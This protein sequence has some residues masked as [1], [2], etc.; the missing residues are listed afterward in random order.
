MTEASDQPRERYLLHRDGLVILLSN[1]Q[2]SVNQKD[3]DWKSL[4]DN[5]DLDRRESVIIRLERI[6]DMLGTLLTL[7]PTYQNLIT[8][9]LNIL[10]ILLTEVK[11]TENKNLTVN[12][13]SKQHFGNKGAPQFDITEQMLEFY[14]ENGFT[15][16]EISQML[17]VSES[18]IKRR[19]SKY[20]MYIRDTYSDL[21]DSQLDK[22]IEDILKEFPN[23]GYKCMRGFLLHRSIKIQENRVRLSMRRVDP[24]G[25]ML[26]TMQSRPIF[27]RKYSVAGPLSL[28]HMD[29]NHKLI[30]YKMVIHGCVDGFTR[31]IIYLSCLNNNRSSNVLKLFT[32]GI[33]TNGLPSRVRGD[34]GGENIGV[35]RFMLSHPLR[36]TKRG[37]FIASKSVHNTRIEKLWGN[38]T[39]SVTQI[40]QNLFM[41]LE[42]SGDLV[43]DKEEDLFCLQFVFLPRINDHLTRYSR[44]WNYHGLS[45]EKYR[46]PNQLWIK[47][48][49]KVFGTNSRIDK[50][51]R[52]STDTEF[53]YTNSIEHDS[54]FATVHVQ[55]VKTPLSDQDL[56]Y[57]K[58]QIDVFGESCNFG[59]DIY[60]RARTIMK[61]IL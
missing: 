20:K 14:I 42:K 37:S 59:G 18:T 23:T 52:F 19:I 13:I 32:N 57:F 27:R 11:G 55:E 56:S 44:G 33:K 2:K 28:W 12:F 49:H 1:I 15:T 34:H 3:H 7:Y 51:V 22:E 30:R 26:R 4:H 39:S 5:F 50:E 10:Y 54:Q 53:D 60:I 45:S 40:Y 46:N 47:G 35:A 61:D 24:E 8:S 25:I 16:K 58:S 21:T 41:A 29:G 9:L 36:G 38:I 6:Y 31:K 48:L 43:V 17:N